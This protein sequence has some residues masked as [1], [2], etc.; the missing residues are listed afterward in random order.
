MKTNEKTVASKLGCMPK[1][2]FAIIK[3]ISLDPQVVVA[4]S[5]AQCTNNE[6]ALF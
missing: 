3:C 4:A 6:E 2:I 5:G 1:Q